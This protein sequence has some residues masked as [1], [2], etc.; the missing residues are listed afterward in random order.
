MYFSADFSDTQSS[1]VERFEAFIRDAAFPC[2][3]AKSAL[4]REGMAIFVAEDIRCP[5]DDVGLYGALR[6]FSRS[7]AEN[8]KPF[9]SFVALFDTAEVLSEA[10]FE[11]TLWQRVQALEAL[12]AASGF[13]YDP[14]VSPN[15]DDRDFSLSFGGEGFFLVGLHPGASRPARRFEVPALVFNP[16]GQFETLRHEGR[17]ET[18]RE[19]IIERDVALSGSANPMLARHG[20]VSE[21]RQYSGR[22][23]GSDWVCPFKTMR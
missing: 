6:D 21:A 15:T 11:R 8:P 3:G 19:R 18:L 13:A 23:V 4:A 20:E 16:H 1:L 9:Q 14:S 22:T 10:A 17:Y 2:V 7:Y 5:R 12:D